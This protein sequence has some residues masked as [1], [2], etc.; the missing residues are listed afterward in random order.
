MLN[1]IFKL[2]DNADTERRI[3]A[4]LVGLAIPI[5]NAHLSTPLPS[6][7]VIGGVTLALGYIVTSTMN[8]M[9]KTKAASQPVTT[10]DQ[11]AVVLA[12]V[13]KS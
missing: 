9:A 1:A 3:A 13:P 7:Q 12:A 11:A 10:V 4:F 2:I 8:A 6:E 5:I